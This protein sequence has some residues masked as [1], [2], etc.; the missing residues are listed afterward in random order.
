[1]SIRVASAVVLSALVFTLLVGVRI[2]DAQTKIVPKEELEKAKAE[3]IEGWNP[4]L[5]INATLNLTSNSNVVGQVDGF[6]TLFGLGLVGGLDY[7]KGKHVVRTTLT[8]TESFARTPVIDEFIKTNDVVGL[9][10]LYN[11]YVTQ[12]LGGYGRLSLQTAWFPADDVRGEPTTWVEK[13][14][15]AGDPPIMLNENALRQRLADSFSPFTFTESVGGFLEPIRRESFN[16][17]LR[18]GV[19]GRHTFA[20]DVRL[21]DDDEATAEVELLSLTNV[22]QLGAE[23][24][25]GAMGKAKEGRLTYRI[26][27]SVL[28]PFVNNDDFDR[29]AT[30]LTRVAFEA[31]VTFS[32]YQWMSLVYSLS[33]VRDPQLFPADNELTQIQ[34]N[35]LLTFQYTFVE[36]KSRKEPTKEEKAL[37]EAQQRAAEAEAE[38]QEL[39]A[40]QV[41]L[42]KELQ[43]SKQPAPSP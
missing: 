31:A 34:N 43:E 35:L 41:E 30:S 42:E 21:I 18:V 26:G 38:M 2:A 32:V 23:A 28:V 33:V 17:S 8:V 14:A 20:D 27:A 1:M 24:F 3:D 36:R 39:K 15:V 5:G 29:S 4:A 10:G 13:P 22:H 7:I 12:S 40:R 11:Y 9:E 37:A 25:L 19:G 6:S 16:L